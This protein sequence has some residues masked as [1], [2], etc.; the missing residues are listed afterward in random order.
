MSKVYLCGT[1]TQDPKCF[2]WRDTVKDALKGT[3]IECLCPTR[4]KDPKEWSANGFEGKGT[5]YDNGAYVARDLSDILDSKAIL[6]V[7]WGEPGRQ[8]IGTWIEMGY[9]L[10][11][12]IPIVVVDMTKEY[13][14]HPF[15]YKNA[16]A[17]F[18]NLEDGITYLRWLLT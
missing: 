6:L 17:T 11:H 13:T 2:K 3:G 5:I 15:I 7:W 10:A 16:A 18:D 8:S 4:N 14:K 9:A 1:M 12:R